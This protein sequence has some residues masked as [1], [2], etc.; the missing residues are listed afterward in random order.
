MPHKP[1]DNERKACDAVARSLEAR[2]GANR[3]NA[4]SPE[5][6]K[7][8]PP[9]E[10]VFNLGDQ[11][12]ALE[13]TIVEAFEGQIHTGVDFGTF[14]AP[15]S[16]ALDHHMPS[17]GTY[18]L[19][20]AIHPSKGMKSKDIPKV[21][22]SIIEWVRTKAADLHGECPEQPPKNHK[23]RGHGNSRND[24][25]GG[26]ELLLYRETGWWMPDK[27]K[28]RLLCSRIAPKDYEVLRRQRLTKAMNKKL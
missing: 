3:S 28:G 25:V 13:H 14:I 1:I 26:V 24:A 12:Y 8:G 17:P 7:I 21:Q 11:K 9:V 4:H 2:A 10:Y 5:D 23:P 20:F 19:S 6:D 16:E 18:Q 15:S 22:A 27:A